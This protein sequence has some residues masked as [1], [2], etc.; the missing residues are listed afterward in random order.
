MNHAERQLPARG[1]L[2]AVAAGGILAAG[3]AGLSM[4]DAAASP[5]S[6]AYGAAASGTDPA[7]P[8]PTVSSGGAVKTASG[9]N[10][11][12]AGTFSATGITV[13]AGAG[14]AESRVGNL[15]VGG[16]SFGSI[17]AT[18]RNGV[19]AVKHSGKRSSKPNVKVSYGSGGGPNVTGITVTISGAG[20]E[21]AE[22]VTAAVVS[23]GKGIPA[24]GPTSPPSRPGDDQHDG[25]QPDRGDASEPG[26]GDDVTAPAPSQR[27]GHLP[28]TG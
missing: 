20:D 6:T 26:I 25:G 17:T 18:C 22:T 2:A 15:T 19:T 23:C 11:G 5:V 14:M 8:R 7:S 13:R 21:P 10:S 1:L 4:A 27:D 9:S 24:D 28:V 3:A 12:K 16:E